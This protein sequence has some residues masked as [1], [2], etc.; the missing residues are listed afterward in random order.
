[1]SYS[2]EECKQYLITVYKD[3]QE[4]GWKR[5]KKYKDEEKRVARDFEYS[6]GR[7]ATILETPEGLKDKTLIDKLD[8]SIDNPLD[9]AQ[10]PAFNPFAQVRGSP[11]PT[12]SKNAKK[13]SEE[14]QFK[15]FMQK[16][17]N[18]QVYGEPVKDQQE[19]QSSLDMM[20]QYLKEQEDAKKN[21]Q[22]NLNDFFNMNDMPSIFVEAINDHTSLMDPFIKAKKNIVTDLLKDVA[23]SEIDTQ[24]EK[25]LYVLVNGTQWEDN[26]GNKASTDFYFQIEEEQKENF[27]KNLIHR[28]VDLPNMYLLHIINTAVAV[29]S[30]DEGYIPFSVMNGEEA[31]SSMHDILKDIVE[32]YEKNNQK[33]AFEPDLI[34]ASIYTLE[35]L[36]E[37]CSMNEVEDQWT[38]ED[39]DVEL[40]KLMNLIK[41]K[42]P[43]KGMKP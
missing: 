3:T 29:E 17:L 22:Q 30:C 14:E 10:E 1:M 35:S 33:V 2:T 34:E 16:V 36:K 31:L 38:K 6:D 32:L 43:K 11:T 5:V 39:I 37:L 28:E 23:F 40:D 4:S 27:I 42:S 21:P 15:E 24:E 25:F 41:S 8:K 12:Y 13:V 9:N 26:D 7:K 20:K 19:P 18:G